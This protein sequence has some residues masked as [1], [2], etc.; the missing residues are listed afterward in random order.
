MTETVAASPRNRPVTHDLTVVALT[1]LSTSY[2][3]VRFVAPDLRGADIGNASTVKLLF[4]SPDPTTRPSERP[5]TLLDL[6]AANGE[7]NVDFVLHD[8][9]GV[10]VDWVRRARTGDALRMLGP[11]GAG[12]LLEGAKRLVLVGDA[13]AVPAIRA[14][15]KRAGPELCADVLLKVPTHGDVLPLSSR[16][17]LNT[18]WLVSDTN[19]PQ[20]LLAAVRA[21]P[22]ETSNV[23]LWWVACEKRGAIDIGTHLQE[24]RAVEANRLKVTPYWKAGCSEDVFHDERHRLTDKTQR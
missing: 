3:R 13:T 20:Q 1:Q 8:H 7:F 16:A 2:K 15:V 11:C 10:A 6:D 19:D 18:Q 22:V 4:P 24:T 14:L 9:A 17:A 23:D 12:M 5:F 21:L